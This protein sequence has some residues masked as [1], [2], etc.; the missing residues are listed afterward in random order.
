MPPNR[1]ESEVESFLEGSHGDRTHI[2]RADHHTVTP[3]C[4]TLLR[5]VECSI[6]LA[7]I[8]PGESIALRGNKRCQQRNA[9]MRERIVRGT[10]T[11]IVTIERRCGQYA[12]VM[13]SF[14][15]ERDHAT[16]GGSKPV[17]ARIEVIDDEQD[18]K[19][20]DH[21]RPLCSHTPI[22]PRRPRQQAPTQRQMT[23]AVMQE[24]TLY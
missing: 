7:P 5:P 20:D 2:K 18:L 17:T 1:F 6:N 13:T 21:I 19:L 23:P 4:G 15:Q 22:L 24:I 11:A 14:T 8:R 9:K 16:R 3:L 12:N 10:N